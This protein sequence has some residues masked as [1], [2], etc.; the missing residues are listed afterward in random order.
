MSISATPAHRYRVTIVIIAL[1]FIMGI[2]VV[3]EMVN[4]LS[5][6]SIEELQTFETKGFDLGIVLAII[7]ITAM[8]TLVWNYRMA[9]NGVSNAAVS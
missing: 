2:V 8:V 5:Q 1:I 4:D 3:T 9:K 6:Y 7:F